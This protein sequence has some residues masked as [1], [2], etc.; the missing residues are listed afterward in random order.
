MNRRRI[1]LIVLV[2]ASMVLLGACRSNKKSQTPVS[3]GATSTTTTMAGATGTTAVPV[4]VAG[5]GTGGLRVLVD[6]SVAG[7]PTVPMWLDTGSAGMLVD[8]AIIGSQA[9]A[10]TG[11][12]NYQYLGFGIQGSVVNASVTLGSAKTSVTTSGAINVGSITGVT[13]ASGSCSI[14]QFFGAGVHGIIGIAP[15]Q[16]AQVSA[17][18]FSPL[19]QVAGPAQTGWTIALPGAGLGSGTLTFGPVTPGKGAVSVSLVQVGSY[20]NGMPAFAKDVDMCWTIGTG[21]ACGATNFDIGAPKT[22]VTPGLIPGVPSA[23]GV[24]TAGTA[25]KIAAP[26]GGGTIWSIKAGVSPSRNLVELTSALGGVT[27][28]NTGIAPFLGQNIAWSVSTAKLYIW[29]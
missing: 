18:L 8:P 16:G 20:P 9:K 29:G 11:S 23:N 2:S 6:A 15:A 3:G 27:Q 1:A 17:P 10:G 24:V 28:Y 19:L 12:V 4:T 22:L 13:C 5:T 14:D 21:S 25:V 26:S 7:G